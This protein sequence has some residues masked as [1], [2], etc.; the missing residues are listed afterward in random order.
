MP[1]MFILFLAQ[2]IPLLGLPQAHVK[3]LDFCA[4]VRCGVHFA[5]ALLS[6]PCPGR[7]TVGPQR[8]L[9]GFSRGHMN[10]LGLELVFLGFLLKDSGIISTDRGLFCAG[11]WRRGWSGRESPRRA[12]EVA[13][14]PGS[15]FL[16]HKPEQKSDP[17]ITLKGAL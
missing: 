15:A 2:L 10:P 4:R 3:P 13:V 17:V 8:L 12:R 16:R 11:P 1:L 7:D 14:P 6:V 5:E 9:A